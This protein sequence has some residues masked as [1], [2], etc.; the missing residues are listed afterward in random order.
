MKKEELFEKY[1]IDKSHNTW[2]D[3]IDN[4]M[5][6]EIYRVM[7]DG[8]LPGD[9]NSSIWVCEFLDKLDADMDFTK[10]MMQRDDFGSLYL[11]AK[12][13]ICTLHESILNEDRERKIYHKHTPRFI[14]TQNPRSGR[15]VKIDRAKG[16]VVGNKAT[17]YKGIEIIKSKKHGK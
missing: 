12:R 4:W 14:Q 15:Y 7:H 6:V 16:S 1:N 13:M 10:K 2:D 5:S 11:T 3:S 17:P 8:V 9:D